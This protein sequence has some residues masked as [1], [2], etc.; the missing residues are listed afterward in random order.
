MEWPGGSNRSVVLITLRDHAVIPNF[1]SAFLR[2]AQSSDISQSVSVL[3]GSHFISYRIGND[4]YKVGTLSLWL[5]LNMFF[6]DYPW[7]MLA[8]ITLCCILLAFIVRSILRRHARARLHGN[9]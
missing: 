6:S 1:L 7:A 2:A 5:H 4:V 9:D 3:H 8:A